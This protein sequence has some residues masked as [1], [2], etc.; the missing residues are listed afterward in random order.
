MLDGDLFDA[1]KSG[2]PRARNP[3]HRR[4]MSGRVARGVAMNDYRFSLII[5]S[6]PLTDEEILDLT[7]ALGEAGCTDASIRGHAQGI[8]LAFERSAESLQDAIR[9][10]IADVQKAGRRVTRVEMEPEA[11]VA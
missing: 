6:S 2:K 7:D 3:P 4:S 1:A 8:E 9:S 11:V 5:T 10:A